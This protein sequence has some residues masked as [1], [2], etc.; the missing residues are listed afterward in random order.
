MVVS[1]SLAVVGCS[2]KEKS[3][4]NT[5]EVT[6]ENTQEVTDKADGHATVG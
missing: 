2:Q 5:T 4:D 1:M 3:K 6:E